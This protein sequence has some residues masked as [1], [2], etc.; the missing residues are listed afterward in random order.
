MLD[1]FLLTSQLVL[2]EPSVRQWVS[3]L[4]STLYRSLLLV[5]FH[6]R[7]HLSFI[8]LLLQFMHDRSQFSYHRLLIPFHLFHFVGTSEK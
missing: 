2:L 5:F 7:I 3:S 1:W 8:H 6:L 4:P